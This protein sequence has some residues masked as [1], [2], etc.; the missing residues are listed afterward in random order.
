MA[1]QAVFLTT[2]HNRDDTRVFHKEAHDVGALNDLE[3]TVIVADGKGNEAREFYTIHDVGCFSNRAARFFLGS[4]KAYNA[5][6][7][8]NPRVVHFHD[9]EL[10]LVTW[11]LTFSGYAVIYDVHENVSEDI[12]DKYWLPKAIRGAVSWCYKLTERLC[13]SRFYKIIAATPDIHSCYPVHKALLVQNFPRL[14]EFNLSERSGRV[15]KVDPYVSYLG[16]I[17]RIRGVDNVVRAMQIVNQTGA[18]V[19]F[20]IGGFFQ[21]VDHLESLSALPAWDYV[22]FLGVVERSEVC[23][24]LSNS[25]CGVVCFL[26]AHNHLKAQ[27]NKL[28]EYM[29]AG[30]PVIASDF[31][32][33]R[34]IIEDYDCGVL[35]DPQSPEDIAQAICYL[36]NDE[37][38]RQKMGRNGVMAVRSFLNWQAESEKLL[39]LYAEIMQEV[40]G[41]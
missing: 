31:P 37:E 16:A 8:L 40:G 26:P 21:Q 14:E 1:M 7:K 36:S 35:V 27:P 22:D 20:K 24:F 34:K 5:V 28:F 4:L 11:L 30:I 29:A 39:G 41:K 13:I 15:N 3:L 9:P 6:K 23:E 2:V 19:R 17:T 10:M 38:R 12:R 33:W 32:L 25:L 18:L